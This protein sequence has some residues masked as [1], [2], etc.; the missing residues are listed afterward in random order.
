L[1]FF[2]SNDT[3]I[4]IIISIVQTDSLVSVAVVVSRYNVHPRRRRRRRHHHCY[5]R[6]LREVILLPLPNSPNLR[7][8]EYLPLQ[9][10]YHQLYSDSIEIQL[11]KNV[12]YDDTIPI[13]SGDYNSSSSSC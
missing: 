11:S 1:S 10:D 13:S 3:I 2:Y 7:L 9:M 8:R 4:I 6:R 5:R 12:R